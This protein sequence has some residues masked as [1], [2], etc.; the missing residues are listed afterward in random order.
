MPDEGIPRLFLGNFDSYLNFLKW[1]KIQ[2]MYCISLR[3]RRCMFPIGD[4]L[5]LLR[6]AAQPFQ[7][8]L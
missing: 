2:S 3:K 1:K 8:S 6:L 4:I 5:Y 7:Q